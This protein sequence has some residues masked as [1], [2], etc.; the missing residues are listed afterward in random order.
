MEIKAVQRQSKKNFQMSKSAFKRALG[1]LMKYKKVKQ[2]DG[3]T[4]LIDKK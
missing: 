1:R 4:F 3:Q 2:A